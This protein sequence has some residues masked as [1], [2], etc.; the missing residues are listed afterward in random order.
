MLPDAEFR[1]A[2]SIAIMQ[3]IMA[4]RTCAC[5]QP[6]DPAGFH[7]LHC[8]YNHYTSLHNNVKDSVAARLRSFLRPDAAQF[9]VLIEQ[10]MHNHYALKNATAP[11]TST[12][13]ADLIISMHA[14]LQQTPIACDFVSCLPRQ[15]RSFQSELREKARVKIRKY[16]A[17][18]YP[19]QGFFPLPFGRTNIL[20][21]DIFDFC[22]RINSFLPPSLKAEQKLRAT[23]SRSIYSGTARL[24]N[25]ALRRL[26]IAAPQRVSDATIP[27]S[28]LLLPHRSTMTRRRV[29]PRRNAFT[30]PELLERLALALDEPNATAAA[31][32]PARPC[33]LLLREGT[34]P[35]RPRNFLLREAFRDGVLTEEESES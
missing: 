16:N 22:S 27:F 14:D 24:F 3:P 35:D 25:F 21:Q 33:N 9:S 15:T 6:I 23:F 26:Q 20:S 5:G 10:P 17:Y 34:H 18:A 30:Q 2:I 19:R 4:P 13:I 7:L 31:P 1:R 11:P 28:S 12:V 29:A 32:H 8:H